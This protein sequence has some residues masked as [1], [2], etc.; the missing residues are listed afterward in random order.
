MNRVFLSISIVMTLSILN[1]CSYFVHQD[2]ATVQLATPTS[3]SNPIVSPNQIV[4]IAPLE[5]CDDH[6]SKS[7]GIKK[8]FCIKKCEYKTKKLAR[9]ALIAL[10]E[11]KQKDWWSRLIHRNKDGIA[12]ECFDH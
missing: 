11:S 7:S 5:S 2:P 9:K 1:G 8:K 6:C 4:K 3:R 12:D 10:C